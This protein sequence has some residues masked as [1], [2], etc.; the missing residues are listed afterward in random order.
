MTV[1]FVKKNY[2]QLIPTL[3]FEIAEAKI[4]YLQEDIAYD[5]S[6]NRM[7]GDH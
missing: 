5:L 2:Y 4:Q 7:A 6:K 3:P 1:S